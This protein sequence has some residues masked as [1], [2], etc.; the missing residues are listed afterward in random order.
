MAAKPEMQNNDNHDHFED[1][2]IKMKSRK[3]IVMYF[4]RK[5]KGYLK[6]NNFEAV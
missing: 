3:K 4:K 2:Y 6:N 5:E 1:N